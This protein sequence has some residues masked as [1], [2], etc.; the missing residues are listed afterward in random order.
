MISCRPPRR[1]VPPVQL[2]QLHRP[3]TIK[4]SRIVQ[5]R[6]RSDLL[7]GQRGVAGQARRRG[8]GYDMLVPTSSRAGADQG[9]AVDRSTSRSC[10][11]EEHQSDLSEHAVRSGQPNIRCLAMSTTII[12]YNDVKMKGAGLPTDTWA[13]IFDP[14]FSRRSRA[15]H[16]ARSSSELF[17]A[18]FNISAT[19]PTTSIRS[20]GTRRRR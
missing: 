9:R 18:A 2:E 17:A 15:I 1:Q 12:G 5:M 7:F 10:E 3:E 14:K 4:R 11:P 16:R 20:T 19:R 6:G 13:V 8:Q